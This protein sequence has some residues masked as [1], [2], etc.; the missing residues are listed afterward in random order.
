MV[1]VGPSARLEEYIILPYNCSLESLRIQLRNRK[2]RI[3]Y[4]IRAV[5]YVKAYQ[6]YERIGIVRLGDTVIF[7]RGLYKFVKLTIIVTI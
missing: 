6:Q 1:A 5:Q 4:D 7:R 3:T 2:A